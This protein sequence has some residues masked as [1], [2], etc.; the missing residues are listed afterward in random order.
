MPLS[1]W[2]RMAIASAVAVTAVSYLAIDAVVDVDADAITK[3]IE[4][5]QA[6]ISHA[7]AHQYQQAFAVRASARGSEQKQRPATNHLC[8]ES[9]EN[10]PQPVR[11]DRG[12]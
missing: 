8:S 11:L 7:V 4:V 12:V 10:G 2:T 3:R 6:S 5:A 1:E 9:Q